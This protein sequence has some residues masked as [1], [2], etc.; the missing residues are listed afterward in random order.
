MKKSADRKKVFGILVLI[1]VGLVILYALTEGNELSDAFIPNLIAGFIG[2]L[3][4]IF[5]IDKFLTAEKTRNDKKYTSLAEKRVALHIRGIQNM[6][7]EIIKSVVIDAQNLYG[8]TTYPELF[9]EARVSQL[10]YFDFK[11][12]PP[13]LT[14]SSWTDYASN[15]LK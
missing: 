2:S 10:R 12:A 9:T 4:T 1:V 8:V 15:L 6:F 7:G 11:Q 5:V 13:E 14:H 3:V